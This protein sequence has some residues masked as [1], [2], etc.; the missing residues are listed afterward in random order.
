[1]AIKQENNG[2]VQFRGKQCNAALYLHYPN[3]T[4]EV[5]LFRGANEHDHTT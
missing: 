1:M 2:V 4:D 3:D 5:V